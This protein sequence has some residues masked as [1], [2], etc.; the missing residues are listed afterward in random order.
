MDAESIERRADCIYKHLQPAA[1][2]I[3]EHCHHELSSSH[4]PELF[5]RWKGVERMK[6][7]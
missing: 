4:A 7:W 3:L 6:G 1:Q 2:S 5:G